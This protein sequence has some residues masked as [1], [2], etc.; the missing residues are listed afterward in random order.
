[1]D[2][3][4]SLA[5]LQSAFDFADEPAGENRGFVHARAEH[6]LGVELKIRRA[7]VQVV[8]GLGDHH[9]VQLVLLAPQRV[10]SDHARGVPRVEET[11][12]Q[13]CACMYA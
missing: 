6:V 10:W 11:C 8:R 4:R 1:M 3:P 12:K 7:Q 13:T 2:S 9:H 5:P